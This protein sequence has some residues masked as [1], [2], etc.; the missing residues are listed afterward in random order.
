VVANR[1]AEQTGVA[2]LVGIGGTVIA[3]KNRN[4]ALSDAEKR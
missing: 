3:F 4:D 2:A 1:L